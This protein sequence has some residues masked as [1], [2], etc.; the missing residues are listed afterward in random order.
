MRAGNDGVIVYGGYTGKFPDGKRGFNGVLMR[1]YSFAQLGERDHQV[2][3]KKGARVSSDSLKGNWRLSVIATSNHA[4]PVGDITFTRRAGATA[5]HCEPVIK[6]EVL[7][8]SFVTDHFTIDAAAPLAKELRS[9]DATTMVGRWSAGIGPLYA[10]F[11]AASPGL[12][13]RET[14]R[15]KKRYILKYVLTAQ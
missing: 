5:V 1:R 12:F 2:L 15:G 4:T 14:A 8:P 9:V 10:R 13:H 3:F 6:P 11:L 7:V